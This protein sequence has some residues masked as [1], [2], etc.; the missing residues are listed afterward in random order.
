MVLKIV[1]KLRA[2]VLCSRWSGFLPSFLAGT[3]ALT[4]LKPVMVN[5]SK[6]TRV[7]RGFRMCYS[8]SLSQFNGS[9]KSLKC[10][11]FR[12]CIG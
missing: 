11:R 2:M 4:D 3:E 8:V 5:N 10:F 12:I 1:Q 7:L 6:L 9:L